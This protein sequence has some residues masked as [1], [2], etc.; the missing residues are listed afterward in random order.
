MGNT[1]FL[2]KPGKPVGA[3]GAAGPPAR[4]AK[5]AA[6]AGGNSGTLPADP[7]GRGSVYPPKP[8]M[9]AGDPGGGMQPTVEAA[10]VKPEAAVALPPMLQ[11]A[12]DAGKLTPEAAQARGVA[13]RPNFAA[14]VKDAAQGAA[15]QISS[16]PMPAAGRRMRP[17]Q[18]V[19]V[20]GGGIPSG[21][22]PGGM[23][24]GLPISAE[25]GGQPIDQQALSNLQQ[26]GLAG[27][28][29]TDVPMG[30]PGGLPYSPLG[31]GGLQFQSGGGLF[32]P[33]NPGVRDRLRAILQRKPGM[34]MPG[35]EPPPSIPPQIA[36]RPAAAPTFRPGGEGFAR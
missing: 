31:G 7:R 25:V 20:Q 18:A 5:P 4:T 19:D 36:G 28:G 26:M 30:Y 27:Q 17:G 8:M 3:G 6:P 33:G 9:S 29:T 16:F 1:S 21:D 23:S 32:S 15:P 12:V 13:N 34:G 14:A 10:Q 22:G 11:A 24:S 35:G 2:A